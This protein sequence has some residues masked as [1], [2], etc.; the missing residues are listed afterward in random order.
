MEND[1][2]ILRHK[3]ERKYDMSIIKVVSFNIRCAND[4]NGHSREE[5][6]PR[7]MSAIKSREPDVIGTKYLT[8]TG[9][10]NGRR[11]RLSS[12]KRAYLSA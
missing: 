12:G 5:R 2:E 7:L 4:K 8:N 9:V 3:T 6:A 11:V 10:K 1:R